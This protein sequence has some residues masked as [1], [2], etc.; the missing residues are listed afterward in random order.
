MLAYDY[1]IMSCVESLQQV[2]K[3]L[4]QPQY[5]A[6]VDPHSYE[7][8]TCVC[9][10]ECVLNAYIHV[11][12]NIC[13]HIDIYVYISVCMYICMHVCVCTCMCACIHA[14]T[15]THEYGV[16]YKDMHIHLYIYTS[17]YIHDIQSQ[18][19]PRL[20]QQ[21]CSNSQ[22]PPLL[23]SQRARPGLRLPPVWKPALPPSQRL[24]LRRI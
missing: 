6:N 21:T 24:G 20:L 12:M 13:I 19:L 8:C 5:E 7:V 3:A 14:H 16:Y 2:C 1:D 23:P 11:R 15:H 10:Y 9:M 18:L 4:Q 17:I 22:L